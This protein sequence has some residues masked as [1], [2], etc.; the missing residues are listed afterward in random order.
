MNE[1]GDRNDNTACPHCGAFLEPGSESCIICG[2]GVSEPKEE[3]VETADAGHIECSSCGTMLDGDA[4]ECFLCDA[5]VEKPA[6]EEGATASPPEK[7]SD[8]DLGIVGGDEDEDAESAEPRDDLSLP[9]DEPVADEEDLMSDEGTES[10]T[11]EPEL[12]ELGLN[13]Y[14]CPSCQKPVEIGAEQCKS[15]W[16]TLPEMIRCPNCETVIPMESESCSE[17]FAKLDKGV[18]LEAPIPLEEEELDIDGEP[19]EASEDEYYDEEVVEEEYTE[20]YG[21]E[22]PFCNALI[23]PDGDI[24]TECGM[25]L[26]EE[27]EDIKPKERVWT[28][29]S[30]PKRDWQKD[31]AMILVFVLLISALTPFLIG[32][33]QVERPRVAIDGMFGDWLTVSNNT[34][35]PDVANPNVNLINYKFIT[36]FSNAYFYAQVDELGAMF[37]DAVG[38]NVRIFLDVDQNEN[39]GYRIKG[40]GAE[41]QIKVFGHSNYVE[42]AA[43]LRFNTARANN[44]INGFVSYAPAVPFADGNEMEVRVNL[45][46]I[47]SSRSSQITAVYY[48]ANANGQ[49]DFS[50]YPATNIGNVLHI[51]QSSAV[52]ASGILTG[53]APVLDLNLSVNGDYVLVDDLALPPGY[54]LRDS[55]NNAATYPLNIT[56][57]NPEIFTVYYNS[58]TAST[59]SLFNYEVTP[60]DITAADADVVVE[61]VGAFAYVGSAPTQ[62]NIDGAFADW[63]D[64]TGGLLGNG[65]A[66]AVDDVMNRERLLPLDAP[67]LDA[68]ELRELQ[69]NDNINL[70]LDVEGLMFAGFDVPV[71]EDIYYDTAPAMTRAEEP[72]SQEWQPQKATI[73]TRQ[74]SPDLQPPTVY[75]PQLGEDVVLVYIDT[76]NDTSDGFL[77]NGMGADRLLDIRGQYGKVT[78]I[79]TYQFDSPADQN[80]ESWARITAPT[81]MAASDGARM[82]A[83][84]SLADLGITIGDGF[85]VHFHVMDWN[86]NGDMGDALVFDTAINSRR[87]TRLPPPSNNGV[88]G[89]VYMPDGI[90]PVDATVIAY[91]PANDCYLISDRDVE[92]LTLDGTGRYLF[93]TENAGDLLS[94]TATYETLISNTE[95]EASGW[96]PT[97]VHNLTLETPAST[98]MSM[99]QA[100]SYGDDGIVLNWDINTP[101]EGGF[102]I[103]RSDTLWG[104]QLLL[105]KATDV[106][107]VVNGTTNW[108]LDSTVTN[109]ESYYY[110]LASLDGFGNEVS[111]APLEK[112]LAADEPTWPFDVYGFVKDEFGAVIPGAAVTVELFNSTNDLNTFAATTDG[113]GRYLVT[114][115]PN[116]F[117]NPDIFND[118]VWCNATWNTMWGILDGYNTTTTLEWYPP[119]N[120]YSDRNDSAICNISIIGLPNITVEKIVDMSIANPGDVLTYTIWFNNTGNSNA[121]FVWINDTLPN[122][123]TYVSDT[124]ATNATH[125]LA[126]S[127]QSGQFLWFNFTNVSLGVHFFNITVDIDS[128]PNLNGTFTNL[129]G[130]NYSDNTGNDLNGTFAWANTTINMPIID[131][132]KTVGVS[133]VNPGDYITYTLYYNNTGSA[134]ATHVWVNDTL[135]PNVTYVSDTNGTIDPVIIGNMYSWHFTDL[136]PGDYFFTVTVQ[137]VDT[138]AN[139]TTLINLLEVNYTAASGFKIQSNDTAPVMVFYPFIVVNKTVNLS[140]AQPGDFLT[141]TIWFNNTNED[142]VASLVWINDTLPAGVIYISDTANL[143][144]PEFQSSNTATSPLLYIFANVGFGDYSFDIIVMILN[145]TTGPWLNNTV[146]CEYI[147]INVTS[148]AWANTSLVL[149]LIDIDKVVNQTYALPG[150]TVFYTIWF[151]NTGSANASYVWIND[152]LP[153]E[154]T[155][156]SDNATDVPGYAS[157]G[158]SGQSLWFNFTNVAPGNYS[159]DIVVQLNDSL[160]PGTSFLNWASLEYVQINGLRYGPY[161]D[162]ALVIVLEGPYI[163]IVKVVSQTTVNTGEIISYIIYFN[164]T[165]NGNA[166]TVWLNDTLPAGVVYNSSNFPFTSTDG[167]TYYWVFTNVANGSNN[168]LVIN[169]LVTNETNLA[170]MINT[171]TCEYVSDTGVA[172]I[173]NSDSATITLMRPII[174]VTKSVDLSIA[175]PGDILFYTINF[176][177][178]G[179]FPADVW[180]NDTLPA[181]V[182][183][184]GYMTSGVVANIFDNSS[185]PLLTWYFASLPV[186]SHW[187]EVTVQID[188][189]TASGLVL[190]NTV[191]LNY[192]CPTSGYQFAGSTDYAVT[193]VSAMIVDKIVDQEFANPGDFL[194][195]TIYFN[196]TSNFTISNIWIN[197]TLPA[198][199]TW[200]NDTAYIIPEFAG[201][202]D[203]GTTWY[204]NF[205]NVGFGYNSFIITVQ[206][207]ADLTPGTWVNNTVDMDYTNDVGDMMPGSSA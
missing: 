112:A 66:D 135:D 58:A 76:N 29:K 143:I 125:I 82:E 23:S 204:Y 24:C 27:D 160:L 78:N 130:L 171:V 206:I 57:N 161:N 191:Q 107:A 68:T 79:T 94:M 106:L 56:A 48:V 198:G 61:G 128:D 15:C 55:A 36:D 190:N 118:T 37:G 89:I 71:V 187:I 43:C 20:E 157:S 137:V 44:D 203:D 168:L 38:D 173:P 197:D 145:S 4:T 86:K 129:V 188:V 88:T 114:L 42:S 69:E 149:P 136:A 150:E 67:R 127:G 101:P 105:D 59:G 47:G 45:T 146:M 111:F 28:P 109:G 77:I 17:C 91:Y 102:R 164:N 207:D 139:G 46:D 5:P 133:T 98:P 115:Q 165:G 194:N 72:V 205:I 120:Y 95:T 117:R 92:G 196:N 131:A 8:W 64:G 121:S 65:V 159:F 19:I 153:I 151:N 51:S 54:T 195:Y 116:H 32:L 6:V 186:G 103:Y 22:C 39:T 21:V 41:Y 152:T 50:D 177:N 181:E 81:A 174:T 52:A 7:S 9:E 179:S 84:I 11:G 201:S 83:S 126:T 189:A 183:Y 144:V 172:G 96:L 97:P 122:N 30:E 132:S 75:K 138:V 167:T 162:S 18:L 200:V 185:S 154:V 70:Y 49:Y 40:I 26:V 175:A 123:T 108:F 33:P 73:G 31:I 13:H 124:A 35:L 85:S 176:D 110:L 2:K 80:N 163:D 182:T 192:S 148:I 141:Y 3:S 104:N 193:L 180:I 178:T 113:L 34:D 60:G 90:T 184:I 25:P 100:Y 158:D 166:A 87:G 14:Y 169:V 63:D 170:D 53:N 93:Y 16:T 62:I 140:I 99:F 10:D 199:V 74:A 1:E 142:S 156:V 202:W 119:L 155:Y 147:P 12:P 134:N